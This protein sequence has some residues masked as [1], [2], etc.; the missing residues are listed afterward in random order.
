MTR[1]WVAGD[2]HPDG[3]GGTCAGA[4][5]VGAAGASTGLYREKLIK[6]RIASSLDLERLPDG[7]QVTTTGLLVVHQAPHTAKGF[8]FLTLEDEFGF[9]NV[10]VRP[11]VEAEF[12][13]V[14]RTGGILTVRGKLQQEGAVTNVKG[15]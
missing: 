2:C 10:I 9:I 13:Q 5:Y 11:S 8:Q 15:V 14:I 1:L 3:S 6:R 12:R 7:I 4:V